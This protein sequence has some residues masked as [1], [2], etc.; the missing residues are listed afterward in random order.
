LTLRVGILCHDGVGGSVRIATQLA[1]ELSSRGHD[2]HVLARRPPLGMQSRDGLMVHTLAKG[3]S[4]R[5]LSSRLE[6]D[7]PAA[8]IHALARLVAWVCRR[9]ELDVLHFHYAYPLAEVAELATRLTGDGPA[10]VGTLHGTDVTVLGRRADLRSRIAASV[11]RTDALTT[12]SRSHADLAAEAFGLSDL[13][14]IIPNFV[15]TDRFRPELRPPGAPERRRIAHVSNFRTIKQPLAVANVFRA[16][17]EHVDAELWLIG[18]GEGMPGLQR[19]LERDGLAEATTCFGLRLD[20][21]QIVSAADVLLVTSHTES[22]CLA[23]LEAG[24]CGVPSV[25]PRVGGIPENVLDGETG[26]LFDPGDDRAA[27]AAIVRLLRDDRR[28]NR[29]GAAAVRRA[30]LLSSR[31]VVPQYEQLYLDVLGASNARLEPGLAQ[32]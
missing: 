23:A 2:V 20:L 22:F 11:R 27:A 31:L 32:S 26:E 29:I 12:V 16:V 7:W 4:S 13:P 18:D 28:R 8:E 19:Q 30:M 6:V 9:E 24:A 1:S 17:R 15:D 25:A 21:E 14:E 5:R 10:V 3:D